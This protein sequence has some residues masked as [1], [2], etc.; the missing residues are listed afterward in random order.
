MKELS[1]EE[2]ARRYDE[3]IEYGRYLI[4]ERC[5][6]GTNGSFHRVDLQRMF[7]ELAESEDEKIRNVVVDFFKRYKE[8]EEC[9][10]K[11]FYGIPTNNII[12]WLGKQGELSICNTPSR[13]VIL[14]I[15]SL[16]NEWKE[17]TH[18]SISTE[19]GTQL[20]YIQK[21]WQESDYYPEKQGEQK[22]T[23]KDEL[24]DHRYTQHLVESQSQKSM[25]QWKG[26]NLK[27]VIDFTGKDR[28]FDKWFK[29]FEEYEQYV[30]KHNG[31]FKLFNTDGSHYE[32][33]VGAWIVKTPDGYNVASK[34]IFKQK[35]AWSE[36]DEN[37]FCKALYF[38]DAG[39]NHF[40]CTDGIPECKDWLKSL[41]D[42]YTWKPS[43]EQIKAIRLA[44]SFVTDDFDEHP[45]LSEVLIE[46][47]E[48]LKKLKG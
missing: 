26:D 1:T 12:A 44:R 30:Q 3:A 37:M 29:S 9:G 6:E 8:R 17:L 36:D 5:K 16:G 34:A 40:K 38:L 41:K 48:Q 15:W 28:N 7:P 35:P 33:P 46:L 19:Y 31:I 10:I 42:R 45:T 18:G 24:F 43:D 47:E 27:E 14:A 23:I 11:T 20:E 13:E 2:K 4:N 39:Y 21:H 22:P 25:I 32:V